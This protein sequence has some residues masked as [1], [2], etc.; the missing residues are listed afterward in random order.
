MPP[1]AAARGNLQKKWT[2]LPWKDLRIRPLKGHPA[3]L[4][5]RPFSIN[6]A[7][8]I[9]PKAGISLLSFNQYEIPS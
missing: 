4:S 7:R 8:V 2:A 3:I 5:D 1:E 9:L 6:A